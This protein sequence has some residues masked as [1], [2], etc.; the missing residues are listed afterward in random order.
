VQLQLP[1]LGELE[2]RALGFGGQVSVRVHADP[3]ATPTFAQSL[4]LLIERL[5]ERG[6][7]G[8]QVVV[9]SR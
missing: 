9:D 8:A 2:I 4:P 1:H 6:L 7:A 5:R 3:A